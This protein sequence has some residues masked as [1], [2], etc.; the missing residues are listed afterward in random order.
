MIK[1]QCIIDLMERYN[2]VPTYIDCHTIGKSVTY[3]F[4]FGKATLSFEEP[5]VPLVAVINSLSR[6]NLE[7]HLNELQLVECLC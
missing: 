4:G 2:I 6:F 5:C 7:D 3:H 1:Q